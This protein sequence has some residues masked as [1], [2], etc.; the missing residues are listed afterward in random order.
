[1]NGKARA[2]IKRARWDNL[3]EFDKMMMGD[4]PINLD[5][6]DEPSK[7]EKIN[8]K[9]AKT[10]KEDL[11]KHIDKEEIKVKPTK[12]KKGFFSKIGKP[13]LPHTVV[14]YG[15]GA[16]GLTGLGVGASYRNKKK[17][18]EEE[19]AKKSTTR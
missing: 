12:P 3:E 11:A 7:P 2:L 18:R 13:R 1:M 10:T 19:L 14:E 9:P 8:T 17:K 4:A 16:I 6:D 15:L 5:M